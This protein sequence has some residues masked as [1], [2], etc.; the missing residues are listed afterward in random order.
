MEH[1][2]LVPLWLKLA[3]G[4]SV[5]LIAIVYWRAYGPSNFLWLSDIALLCTALAVITENGLLASMPAVGVL[6]LELA[7]TLDFLAGGRLIGLAAY[8]FDPR[9]SRFLRALSLFHLALP[10]T[11]IWMLFRFGYDPT[12]LVWQ[13]IVTLAALGV[14]YGLTEPDKNINWVFGPGERPQKRLPPLLYLALELLVITAIMLAM[15]VLLE[16]V[17]GTMPS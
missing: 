4:V 8:M 2:A 9:Y 6:P 11:L 7:W 10:P 14:S 13:A 12:A 17:F 5:P 16:R 15:H 3:Y 1:A